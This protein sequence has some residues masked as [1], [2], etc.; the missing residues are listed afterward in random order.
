MPKLVQ[1]IFPKRVWTFSNANNS[2]YLTLDDGPIPNVTP[3]VLKQLE[4]HRAKA[5]FFCIGDN[6]RK[7]PEI[8]KR[9]ISE[10]HTIGNHTFNHLNGSLTRSEDY[11]ENVIKAEN[12]MAKIQASDDTSALKLFRPPY[13]KLSSKKSKMLQKLGYKIIMW[14]VL[15]ADFD[16][17]LSEEKVLQNV[18]KNIKPGSIVIFH[19]SLKAEKNLRFVLPKVLEFISEKGWKC[20]AIQKKDFSKQT[21]L[22]TQ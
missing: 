16:A 15:S 9:I 17:N 10:E 13:G 14:D 21:L 22:P 12:A 1:R 19:D 2:V 18:I 7:H 20:E 4:T 8:F 11:I 5:T 3:W 6:V